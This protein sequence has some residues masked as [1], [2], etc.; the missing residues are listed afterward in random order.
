MTYVPGGHTAF[1]KPSSH[2]SHAYL[3]WLPSKFEPGKPE[4]EATGWPSHEVENTW[5]SDTATDP[6]PRSVIHL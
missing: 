5:L 6:V 1:T 2:V 3:P 4:Y